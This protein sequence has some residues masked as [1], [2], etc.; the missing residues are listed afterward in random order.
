MRTESKSCATPCW[1]INQKFRGIFE[2]KE[3]GTAFHMRNL[4]E[5]QFKFNHL[6]GL[7][8]FLMVLN[9]LIKN[10]E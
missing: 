4:H 6:E 7:A 2:Y 8:D 1:N 9:S 5:K 3:L 10:L